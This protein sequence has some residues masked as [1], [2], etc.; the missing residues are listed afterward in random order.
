MG[1]DI[2]CYT[3]LT[4]TDWKLNDRGD[5]LDEKGNK[6]TKTTFSRYG[7]GEFES[8]CYDLEPDV[9]YTTNQPD[10]GFRAG[11]YSYYNQ[12]RNQLAEVAGFSSAKDAWE[13]NGG[14]FWELINFS[15]C[16][17]VIGPTISAK[18]NM[19]FILFRDKAL[20]MG[21]EF[22]QNYDDFQTAFAMASRAGA[23]VFC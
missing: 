19:D 13:A 17:G 11:S 7:G 3:G 18:L 22:M 2:R 6:V 21:D 23:V 4:K 1:L 12:W 15:D 20:K 14:P 16:D 8:R 9:V 5:V 10:F